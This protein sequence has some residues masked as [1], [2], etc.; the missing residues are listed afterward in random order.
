M[1]IYSFCYIIEHLDQRKDVVGRHSEDI[2]EHHQMTATW[3][4]SDQ[5]GSP[6][7]QPCYAPINNYSL[8]NKRV[9]PFWFVHSVLKQTLSWSWT[10]YVP[11]ASP[12]P[13][14][15][16]ECPWIYHCAYYSQTIF[17]LGDAIRTENI[18]CATD[19][20]LI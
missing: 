19:W 17:W 20:P 18:F 9:L 1:Y 13:G 7:A 3:E 5:L 16:S 15:P 4:H 14:E 8:L 11:E 2:T 12:E 6:T 10:Y